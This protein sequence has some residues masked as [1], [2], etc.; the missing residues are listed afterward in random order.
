[1]Y[2]ENAASRNLLSMG[3]H[4]LDER[5][6]LSNSGVVMLILWLF[7]SPAYVRFPRLATRVVRT[8]EDNMRVLSAHH[9]PQTQQL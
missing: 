5:V 3:H 9:F 8:A 6:Q 7:S 1:M 4:S 2:C